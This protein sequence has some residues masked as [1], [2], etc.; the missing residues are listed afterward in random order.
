MKKDPRIDEYIKQAEPFA[1]PILEFYRE[2]IHEFCPEVEEDWKWKY[3]HFIYKGKILSAMC[4]FK[5]HCGIGFWLES[6]METIKEHRGRE[7]RGMF[8]F[9]KIISIKDLP[10]KKKLGEIIKEAM[11]LTDKGVKLKKT[12]STSEEVK[13]P[14]YFNE[15]L[16]TSKKAQENFKKGSPSFRKEYINWITEAKTETTRNKRIEQ[17]IEWITEGKGRNWKYEKKK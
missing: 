7:N 15:I 3:P 6:E 1:Q 11:D 12:A 10:P 13:V 2:T 16:K 14:E 4:G 17:A 9:N 8:T 5:K